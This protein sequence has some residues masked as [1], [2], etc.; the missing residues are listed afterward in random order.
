MG[1]D[2]PSPGMAG[3]RGEAVARRG[4][5]PTRAA[6][7]YTAGTVTPTEMAPSGTQRHA[8]TRAT[9]CQLR[10]ARRVL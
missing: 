8:A 6:G 2:F 5:H 3:A 10:A 4:E 1:G 9:A 7:A